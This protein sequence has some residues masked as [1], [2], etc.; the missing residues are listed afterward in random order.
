MKTSNLTVYHPASVED[1]INIP[2]GKLVSLHIP[3]EFMG[4][5]PYM[6]DYVSKKQNHFVRRTAQTKS[7]KNVGLVVY[8]FSD[9]ALRGKFDENGFLAPFGSRYNKRLIRKEN[10]KTR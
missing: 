9:S 3:F 7:R 8:S 2:D 6:R 4:L 5:A 1:L 10:S